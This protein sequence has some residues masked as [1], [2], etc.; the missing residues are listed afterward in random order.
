[1]GT[2]VYHAPDHPQFPLA[3]DFSKESLPDDAPI[4]TALERIMA[5]RKQSDP[6]SQ[7][8]NSIKS[9][10]GSAQVA[11][12]REWD[13]PQWRALKVPLMCKIYLRHLVRQSISLTHI[14]QL[15]VDFNS[16]KAMDWKPYQSHIEQLANMGFSNAQAVEALVV[17]QNRGVDLACNFLFLSDTEQKVEREKARLATDKCVS[18]DRHHSQISSRASRSR[19]AAS[20]S[21]SRNSD[22]SFRDLRSELRKLEKHLEAEKR[23]QLK[24][25]SEKDKWAID[26]YKGFLRGLTANR[27]LS[28]PEVRQMHV[29][30]KKRK[31][32]DEV[33]KKALRELGLTEKSIEQMKEA[34]F[35]KMI[36]PECSICMD[37]TANHLILG[38]N[39]SHM[40]LCADCS[41]DHFKEKGSKCPLCQVEIQRIV[42]VRM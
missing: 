17:T 2:L 39:C 19:S 26:V 15:E 33:H 18:P 21:L 29:Y 14:Q 4:E 30:R 10:I 37:A 7:I 35:A 28:D 6:G 20:K 42:K 1:M 40:C 36:L 23:K 3:P 25:L 34:M 38:E 13:E 11:A 8:L 41:T 31:I 16:G 9:R 24:M 12:L 5:V 22:L 27:V 32:S